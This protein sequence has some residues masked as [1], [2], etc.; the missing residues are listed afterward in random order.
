[1]Y[2]QQLIASIKQIGDLRQ[3]PN[4]YQSLVDLFATEVSRCF[5]S[6]PASAAIPSVEGKDKDDLD[7]EDGWR[8]LHRL[9]GSASSIGAVAVA[10]SCH[11]LIDR[12][13]TTLASEAA[14]AGAEGKTTKAQTRAEA[15]ADIQ[16]LEK[17]CQK[18]ILDMR[19]F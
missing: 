15:N 4:Y 10:N 17:Q 11:T 18:A 13:Q 6:F 9:K 12:W 5:A 16:A 14:E 2:D 1:M 3:K 7:L 8:T 19:S